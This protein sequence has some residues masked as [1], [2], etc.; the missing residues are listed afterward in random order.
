MSWHTAVVTDNR[1]PDK[2][3]RLKVKIPALFGDAEYPSWVD[4]AL[5]A[6]SHQG[7]LGLWCVPPVDA[8]IL[9]E[10]HGPSTYWWRGGLTGGTHKLPTELSTDYPKRAGLTDPSGAVVLALT[11]Q[12][13]IVKVPRSALIGGADADQ[14]S[15]LGSKFMAKFKLFLS[16]VNTAILAVPSSNAV[17]LA[18]ISEL[19]AGDPTATAY[20]TPRLKVKP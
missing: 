12:D 15:M 14:E 10:R 2:Q 17:T 9:V 7:A 5:A 8:V 18:W 20:T 16:E 11:E 6:P 13:A 4:P 19:T 1:D 3:G